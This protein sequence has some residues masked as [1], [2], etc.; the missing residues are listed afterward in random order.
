MDDNTRQGVF[1]DYH[2]ILLFYEN[3]ILPDLDC[4]CYTI[5]ADLCLF[6]KDR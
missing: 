3:Y 4:Y 1:S 5:R 2:Q 6:G